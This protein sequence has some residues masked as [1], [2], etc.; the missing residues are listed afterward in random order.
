MEFREERTGLR[1]ATSLEDTLQDAA[2]IAMGAERQDATAEGI[3][4]EADRLRIFN[5]A[6]EL[7]DDVV[8]ILVLHELEHV[9]LQFLSQT[10]TDVVWKVV[11]GLLD[12]ATAVCAEGKRHDVST[13]LFG[14]RESLRFGAIL[15]HLLHDVVAKDVLHERPRMWS[16]FLKDPFDLLGRRVV[17]PLLSKA[18]PMLIHAKLH[19]VTANLVEGPVCRGVGDGWGVACVPV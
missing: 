7:L 6:E 10:Q 8:C 3:R 17:E 18:T 15:E 13:H 4:D 9:T 14:E 11:E 2:R 1:F 12:H 5:Y 19:D 16:N